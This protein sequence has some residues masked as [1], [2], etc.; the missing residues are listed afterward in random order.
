MDHSTKVYMPQGA[1]QLVV[2]DGG[3]IDVKAGGQITAAGTQAAAI[4][5][6]TDSTGGTAD[7]TLEAIAGSGAD[8]GI[9]NNFASL[10][11]KVNAMQA[12]LEGVG[13]IAAE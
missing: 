10:A 11:A 7:D 9:N 2:D 3:K 6:L 8:A 1:D 4:P 13:I 12:A 5:A